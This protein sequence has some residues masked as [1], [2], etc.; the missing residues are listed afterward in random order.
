MSSSMQDNNNKTVNQCNIRLLCNTTII[1][2]PTGATSG[3]NSERQKKTGQ[4]T[5]QH[6]RATP[7]DNKNM[8]AN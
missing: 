2:Q 1:G 6:T 8:A 3:G 7:Q 4:P 5:G